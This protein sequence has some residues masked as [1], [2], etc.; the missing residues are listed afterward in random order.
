MRLDATV[1]S[2]RW[3]VNA[4][5]V[6]AE[7]RRVKPLFPVGGTTSAALRYP[8][9]GCHCRSAAERDKQVVSKSTPQIVSF[10]IFHAGRKMLMARRGNSHFEVAQAFRLR[11]SPRKRPCQPHRP[12]PSPTH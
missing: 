6:V 5:P 4:T 12:K 3:L 9:P 1:R 7:N 2:D 8:T 10:A 11:V